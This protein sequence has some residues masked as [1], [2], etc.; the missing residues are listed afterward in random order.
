MSGELERIFLVRTRRS[1]RTKFRI[2]LKLRQQITDM[3]IPTHTEEQ[4]VR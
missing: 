3:H 2:Y 1:F 4:R